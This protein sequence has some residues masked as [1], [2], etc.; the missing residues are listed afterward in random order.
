MGYYNQLE[1]ARPLAKKDEIPMQQPVA[2]ARRAVRMV[3]VAQL[4]GLVQELRGKRDGDVVG[5]MEHLRLTER[6]SSPR[7][8]ALSSELPGVK[9]RAALTAVGDASV[10]LEPPESEMPDKAAP[11]PAEQREIASRAVMYLKNV[12]PKLPNF[13]ARRLTRSFEGVTQTHDANLDHGD[14]VLRPTGEFKVT[15]IYRDGK[16]VARAEGAEEQRLITR[17]T[18]GPILSTVILDAA[19]SSTKWGRWEEGPNGPMAVLKVRVPTEESHYQVSFPTAMVGGGEMSAMAPTAYHAEIGIDPKSG[20]ILRLVL[21]AD[22]ELGSS[23]HR[24]DIMVEYGAVVIG[25]KVYTCPIRGVSISAGDTPRPAKD[26]G[27]AAGAE[28]GEITRLDDVVFSDYHVFR[29][30]MR[31]VP[32]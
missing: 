30:E 20:T 22:A 26:I 7:L 17:G 6:L 13:S 31:I 15:V 18:F 10:F 8:A 21:E 27:L 25:G 23:M 24:A 9:S 14:V 11:S 16:E 1:S 12:I 29:S 4:T 5:D 32:E 2:G 3:T 19:H 28:M